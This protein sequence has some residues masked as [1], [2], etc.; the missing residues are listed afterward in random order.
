MERKVELALKESGLEEKLAALAKQRRAL[1]PDAYAN[2]LDPLVEH[3]RAI[4]IAETTLKVGERLPFFQLPDAQGHLVSSDEMLRRGPLAVGFF[5]GGWC[6]YCHVALEALAE[7]HSDVLATGGSLVAI[8]PDL[9]PATAQTVATLKLPF[10]MLSDVDSAFGVQCGVIYRMPD[11]VIEYYRPLDI[12]R[13]HG[14]DSHFFP[15]PSAFIADQ[16]GT[17]RYAFADPDF[18]R[19]PE[20]QTLIATLRMLAEESRS[21][22]I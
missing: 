5:R 15:I 14:S 6:P 1:L 11:D 7:V 10:E 18:T 13:R 20:P 9:I 8:T 16:S 2:I 21:F 3:L 17:I 4:G 19:K 22:P 12:P